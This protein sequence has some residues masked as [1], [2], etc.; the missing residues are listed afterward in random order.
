MKLNDILK[1]IGLSIGIKGEFEILLT[2]CQSVANFLSKDIK[3]N[4]IF[5][6][7]DKRISFNKHIK[8]E[9]TIQIKIYPKLI[10]GVLSLMK[11][12]PIKITRYDLDGFIGLMNHPKKIKTGLF[13]IY[14]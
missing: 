9:S 11:L 5:T 4:K 1:I 2:D 8:P 3:K 13:Q 7:I 6:L 14:K 12:V 10:L